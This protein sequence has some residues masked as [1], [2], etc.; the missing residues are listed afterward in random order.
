M[1]VCMYVRVWIC[2]CVKDLDLND[3]EGLIDSKIPTNQPNKHNHNW[4]KP[5]NVDMKSINETIQNKTSKI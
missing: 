4:R 5:V 1:Y 2:V 3:T